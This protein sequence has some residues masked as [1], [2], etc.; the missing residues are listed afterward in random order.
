MYRSL[1]LLLLTLLLQTGAAATAGAAELTRGSMLSS[2]CAGCHGPDGRSPG[3]IPAISGKSA[4]FIRTALDEFR[5]GKRASTVMGRHAK[6]YT[7]EEI[8]LIADYLASRQ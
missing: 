3:A 1:I 2:S 5:S 6:A 8:A 7:D 4:E